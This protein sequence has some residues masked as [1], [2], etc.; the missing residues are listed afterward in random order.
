LLNPPV[1]SR[2]IKRQCDGQRPRCR[3]CLEQ[4]IDC[5]YQAVQGETLSAAL[6]RKYRAVEEQNAQYQELYSYIQSRPY[7][8]ALEIFHRIRT[9]QSPF[10][11]L[12][13]IN[14]ADTLLPHSIA[15][16][17]GGID[18][19]LK[20]LNQD[21]LDTAPIK[22]HAR[23]WT[24]VADDGIVSELISSFFEIDH[25]YYFPAIDRDAFLDEMHKGDLQKARYCS[26]L[27]VNSICAYRCVSL[28]K[29]AL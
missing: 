21:A 14:E 11:V 20:K 9:S 15:T 8:E 16:A 1:A 7:Q 17:P 3:K 28:Q 5:V 10:Q 12:R 4:G 19:G 23:P 13:S 25:L 18:P 27:L 22:V 2:F 6:K 26:P 24:I 29:I